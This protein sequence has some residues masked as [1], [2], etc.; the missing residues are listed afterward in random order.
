MA[1][2]T[3]SGDD[4]TEDDVLGG[5]DGDVGI[6]R[7]FHR[8]PR[9]RGSDAGCHPKDWTAGATPAPAV[10]ASRPRDAVTPGPLLALRC[11]ERLEPDPPHDLHTGHGEPRGERGLVLAFALPGLVVHEEAFLHVG[12]VEHHVPRDDAVLGAA[13]EGG[14]GDVG[15]VRSGADDDLVRD[16]LQVV[17]VHEPPR[18]GG[19][20]APLAVHEVGLDRDSERDGRVR[21]RVRR[22]EER[23]AVV[24][25]LPPV[26]V[27]EGQA[28]LEPRRVIAHRLRVGRERD[29]CDGR[30]GRDDGDGGRGASDRPGHEHEHGASRSSARSTPST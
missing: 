23:R 5:L 7:V 30:R 18:V 9:S 13:G 24:V 28:Q 16:G 2:T 17:I 12:P 29:P 1:P 19:G 4:V 26:A 22:D 21:R 8:E 25:D 11:V 6:E 15:V 27:G 3:R 14:D 10:P 20:L